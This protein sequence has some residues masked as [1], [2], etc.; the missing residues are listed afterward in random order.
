MQK[1]VK[2]RILTLV[3]TRWGVLV[4]LVAAVWSLTSSLAILA[5]VAIRCT[6][7]TA[8]QGLAPALARLSHTSLI[9]W[10]CAV[11]LC[12]SSS[13]VSAAAPGFL[14]WLRYDAALSPTLSSSSSPSSASP[15]SDDCC[16]GFVDNLVGRSFQSRLCLPVIDVVYTWV[17]GSD[18]RWQAE[19]DGYRRQWEA[20]K[21]AELAKIAP[22]AVAA[23]LN[24]IAAVLNDSIA[25]ANPSHWSPP[26]SSTPSSPFESDGSADGVWSN[27]SMPDVFAANRFRDNEELRYSLRSLWRFAPWVRHVFVVTN[28]QVPV[29]LNLDHPR[30]TVVQHAD[31]YPN[32][33]HLPTFS[34][35]SI[36]SHLHRIPGLAEHFLYFNDDVLL[37]A[38]VWPDDFVLTNGAQKVFLSWSVPHCRTGCP[39]LWLGDGYCD[40][41][42]NV[43]ECNWDQGDCVNAT[44]ADGRTGAW[45]ANRL[46]DPTALRY[47]V[48][49][50]PNAWVG[51]KVCDRSCKV[52]E[53]AFDGGD[54]GVELIQQRLP[55]LKLTHNSTTFELPYA[56]TSLF[57]NLSQVLPG[58]VTE[59]SHDNHEL[60]RSAIVTQSLQILTLIL[61]EEEQLQAEDSEE[62]R[63]RVEAITRQRDDANTGNRETVVE[64]EAADYFIPHRKVDIYLAGEVDGE[65]R[66][67]SFSIQRTRIPPPM[68]STIEERRRAEN[69]TLGS[70]EERKLI[71]RVMR[72]GREHGRE[73]L[74]EADEPELQAKPST[75]PPP[76]PPASSPDEALTSASAAPSN[77]SLASRAILRQLR[78]FEH[79]HARPQLLSTPLIPPRR[80]APRSSP[81]PPPTPAVPAALAFSI[82]ASSRTWSSYHE[83]VVEGVP[84]TRF[85]H[86][87]VKLRLPSSPSLLQQSLVRVA[88][89]G[90]FELQAKGEPGSVRQSYLVDTGQVVE[91]YGGWD[92][93]DEEVAERIT[94][95]KRKELWMADQQTATEWMRKTVGRRMEEEKGRAS[96]IW[97]WELGLDDSDRW[98]EAWALMDEVRRGAEEGKGSEDDAAAASMEV[99]LDLDAADAVGH[100]Q[101]PSRFTVNRWAGGDE[102]Q[103]RGNGEAASSRPRHFFRTQTVDAVDEEPSTPPPAEFSPLFTSAD[104]NS[105]LNASSSPFSRLS[106]LVNPNGR[107]LLDTYGDSLRHVTTLLSQRYGKG[108]NRK[109]PAHMPHLI[110]RRV[111]EQ[112]QAKWPDHYE[113]TSAHRFRHPADMQVSQS[114]TAPRSSAPAHP[115]H[116]AADSWLL[117]CALLCGRWPLR[118]FTTS[119]RSLEPSTWSGYGASSWTGMATDSWTSTS[120]A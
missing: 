13:A 22:P 103:H 47:C 16:S 33:S 23:T 46:K 1:V 74:D 20:D 61:Y 113:A 84:L 69:S 62:V 7:S 14:G 79:V 98:E 100:S 12:S 58:K 112:L 107:H 89:G 29:W 6:H 102:E 77:S 114:A 101:R 99:H 120:C 115:R 110:D 30:L 21:A 54:C 97:P 9:G 104:P 34:S 51:D 39:D 36:E 50:C 95:I 24:T 109:A 68:K 8:Q 41:T 3:A 76:P 105:Y 90:G 49:G 73:L 81:E 15:S 27:G 31:I 70:R 57:V 67:V 19:L 96:V 55:E 52:V 48:T 60:V 66:N 35:P 91:L 56:T 32:A 11:L 5:A 108:Q 85:S 94:A 38:P 43:A 10:P 87:G 2:S 72:Y 118:T 106:P 59:A 25:H 83:V 86:G 82:A 117:I 4:V 17:N 53:C 93:E 42:C 92:A 88:H 65:A 111:M 64:L 71:E 45:D 28:G 26:S 44:N 37:G 75:P 116:H 80:A 18:E 78:S 119:C 63:R 40:L